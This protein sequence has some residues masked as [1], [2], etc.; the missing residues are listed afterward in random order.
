MDFM[1]HLF[2]ANTDNAWFDFL[3]SEPNVTEVNFWW[4]G[5]MAFRAIQ[6]GELLAFR[7]KSPRNKIGGFGVFSSHSLL[8]VQ[9]AWDSFGRA[10][11]V[12]WFEALRSAIAEYRAARSSAL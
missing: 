11:G 8:P 6:A 12:P 4:P 10:N 1:V 5:E 3:S 7:L 9:I 2:V